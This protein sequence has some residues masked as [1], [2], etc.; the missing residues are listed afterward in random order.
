MSSGDCERATAESDDTTEFVDSLSGFKLRDTE[1]DLRSTNDLAERC[2]AKFDDEK[3]SLECRAIALYVVAAQISSGNRLMVAHVP[4]IC[5]RLRTRSVLSQPTAGA[6]AEDF[7][8]EIINSVA[9]VL[10]N[11]PEKL[12]DR[13]FGPI[14]QYLVR[15]VSC[16]HVEVAIHACEFWAKYAAL[17]MAPAARRQWVTIVQPDLPTLIGALMDQMIYRPAH[18]EHLEQY[19]S[20]CT[21]PEGDKSLRGDVET[22]ANVR[23]FAA[24]AVEQIASIFPDEGLCKAFLPLLEKRI[25]SETWSDKEAAIL[26]LA[27]FTEGTGIPDPMR[28]AYAR[29]VP[30]VIDCYAD[31]RPLLR[32]IAC[33]TMPK[34][35]GHRIRGVK[36]PWPRV[37]SCTAKAT[38][39]PCAEVRSVAMRALSTLL[40]YGHGNG[41]GGT[42]S[43]GVATHAARLVD[44][45]VRAGQCDMDP[46][47]RCTYF[48]CVSHLMAR[49]GDSL[50]P[51]D[52]DRLLPPLVDAW[53]SQPWDRAMD[54]ESTGQ[55]VDDLRLTVVPFSMDLANI[56]NYAAS[57]YAPYAESIFE[58][59]CTD[60]KGDASL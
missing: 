56:A 4:D 32:S 23:N 35:V 22:F 15:M 9:V 20:R 37:L 43:S 12:V 51:T 19:V 21:K 41:G 26:A 60:I 54:G 33:F 28:D 14:A 7:H 6:G 1:L 17:P 39:D 57:L 30:R 53:K 55:Y 48:D 45:L 50:A 24:S 11:A 31:A 2:L 8:R 16:K 27:A 52:V 49:A 25:E 18:A 47:T 59:A 34:L 58:K 3:A 13:S 36:D 10:E 44:A 46:E 42:R 40:A 29:I 38:R 5:R